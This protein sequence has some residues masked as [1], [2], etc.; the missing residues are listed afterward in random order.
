MQESFGFIC[1]KMMIPCISNIVDKDI[2]LKK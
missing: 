1:V 2:R